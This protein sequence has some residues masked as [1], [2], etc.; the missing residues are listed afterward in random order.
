[1]TATGLFL[2]PFRKIHHLSLLVFFALLIVALLP[3]AH[4]RRSTALDHY[5]N[6]KAVI[7][8]G[9]VP[10][11]ECATRQTSNRFAQAEA[12]IRF[13]ERQRNESAT[14]TEM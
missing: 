9:Y 3:M 11:Y 6:R 10:F 2:S 14:V 12:Q 1:M 8:L 4:T 7:I 13:C 5:Y